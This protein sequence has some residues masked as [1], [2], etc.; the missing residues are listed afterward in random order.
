RREIAEDNHAD[1]ADIQVQREAPGAVLELEQLVRHGRRQ[2][3]DP[4][5]AV[6]ALDDHAHLFGGSGGRLVLLDETR[7]RVLDLLG[8][9]SQLRHLLRVFLVWFVRI[10]IRYRDSLSS[11]SLSSSSTVSRCLV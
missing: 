7:E 1:L 2:P 5:D 8:P 10:E 6:A 3:F 4:C 11:S 9:D